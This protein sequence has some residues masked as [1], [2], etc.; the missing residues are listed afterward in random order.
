MHLWS[1][2]QLARD[3]R[4][5]IVPM[6]SQL[7]YLILFSLII[8]AVSEPYIAIAEDPRNLNE[9]DAMIA[10]ITL[11]TSVLGPLACYRAS[12]NHRASNEFIARFICLGV[13]VYV[14]LA[15]IAFGLLAL[16]IVAALFYSPISEYMFESDD[17]TWPEVAFVG[18]FECA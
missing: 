17:T 15:V 1:V 10:I 13:P 4:A 7:P 8:W 2:R 5:G 9:R 11:L 3:F 16:I 14:Q 18:A 6:R 12:V